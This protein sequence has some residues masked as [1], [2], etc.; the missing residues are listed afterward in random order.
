M[1]ADS[2]GGVQGDVLVNGRIV[3]E[4][5]VG[6]LGLID[7]DAAAALPRIV[8]ADL[9]AVHVDGRR[10]IAVCVDASAIGVRSI[11]LNGGI[12]FHIY[13][14]FVFDV[15]ASPQTTLILIGGVVVSGNGNAIE[16]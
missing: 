14:A 15:D 3:L 10:V 2:A 16:G 13:R 6:V 9:G 5:D 1:E 8:L 4:I 12:V 7:I 11:V